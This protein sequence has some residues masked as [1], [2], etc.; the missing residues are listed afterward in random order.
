MVKFVT[1]MIPIGKPKFSFNDL[2]KQASMKNEDKVVKTA[3]KED[4]KEKDE[5]ASSGQPEAEGKLTN[6]PKVIDKKKDDKKDSKPCAAETTKVEVKEAAK[7]CPPDCKCED[8]CECKGGK[9]ACS[10][11]KK[12]EKIASGSNSDDKAESSGQPEAEGKLTNCPKV[13]DEKK[14]E[15]KKEDK[16][17]AAVATERFVKIAKLNPETKNMLKKYW[18]LLYPSEYVEAMLAEK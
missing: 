12:A 10:H 6:C 9:K 13:V 1:N 2:V 17:E 7:K 18:Q 15:V 5:A 4:K 14:K 11:G 16:K 3:A 8:G